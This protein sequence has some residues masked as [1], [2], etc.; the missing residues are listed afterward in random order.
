MKRAF[1]QAGMRTVIASL[2]NIDDQATRA[3]M[4]RFFNNLL[5]KKLTPLESLRR[6]RLSILDDPDFGAGGDPRRGATWA[7]SDD[8]GGLARIAQ[9][10]WHKEGPR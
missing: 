3:L 10:A 9:A 4:N 2:W 7:L 1:H 5:E 6:A 8:P